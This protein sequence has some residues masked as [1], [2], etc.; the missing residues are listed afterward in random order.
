MSLRYEDKV[1][2]DDNFSSWK[3]HITIVLKMNGLWD[4][5]NTEIQVPSDPAQAVEHNQ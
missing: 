4:F 2:G 1:D 5:L 3:E